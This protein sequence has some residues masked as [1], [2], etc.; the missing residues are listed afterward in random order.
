MFTD[1]ELDLIEM[2][3]E[4][5]KQYCRPDETTKADLT[6]LIEKVGDTKLYVARWGIS[7]EVKLLEMRQDA[8]TTELTRL[9]AEIETMHTNHRKV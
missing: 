5:Y 6:T 1:A 8:L 2:V 7:Q 9:Q 4:H 3:L